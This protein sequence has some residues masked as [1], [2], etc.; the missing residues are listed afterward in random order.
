[1]RPAPGETIVDVGAYD[2]AF[3]GNFFPR[4]MRTGWRVI[5]CDILAV[6]PSPA[7]DNAFVANACFLPLRERSVDIVF[8]NSVL[9][10]VGDLE[11]QR[12]Y[13]TEIQRVARRYFVEVPNKHF[14]IEPHFYIPF[15]QYL[16]TRWQV[17]ITRRLFNES[18]EIRLPDRARLRTLFPAATIE[19]ERFF[20]LTKAFYVWD[21]PAAPGGPA[22]R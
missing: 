17:A 7:V 4:Q 2:G 18:E 5:T 22:Q 19:R 6:R 3:W 14:P 21:I 12:R 20:G 1:M 15:L 8:S 10:H 9:E 16:P 13:A 11:R